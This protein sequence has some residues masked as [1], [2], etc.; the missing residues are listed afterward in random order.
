MNGVG[1]IRRA[2]VAV[3]CLAVGVC[4]VAAL[5]FSP[6]GALGLVIGGGC[7]IFPFWIFGLR[8]EQFA[9]TDPERLSLVTLRWSAFRAGMSA[10]AIVGGYALAPEGTQG[11]AG[12]LGGL[13]VPRIVLIAFTLSGLDLRLASGERKSTD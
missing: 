9:G 7:T 6:S 13:F 5:P 4:A 1:K 12:A 10:A 2:V 3:S 11:L 8:V